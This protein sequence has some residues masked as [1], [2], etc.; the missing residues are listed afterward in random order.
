MTKPVPARTIFW[1]CDQEKHA[2]CPGEAAVGLEEDPKRP[3][4]RCACECH[5][6]P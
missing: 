5:K 6:N 4:L 1:P 2:A 3:I